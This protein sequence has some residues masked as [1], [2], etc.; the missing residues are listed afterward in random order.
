MEMSRRRWLFSIWFSLR[1]SL[2]E[3]GRLA[4]HLVLYGLCVA[5]TRSSCGKVCGSKWQYD[6]KS[7]PPFW[8]SALQHVCD[9]FLHSHGIRAVPD[10]QS[11]VSLINKTTFA[12]SGDC[13]Q[14]GRWG[15][16]LKSQASVSRTVCQESTRITCECPETRISTL[17]CKV[18][19][20]SRN[21]SSSR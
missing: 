2:L 7:R 3:D 13:W 10:N 15:F 16:S 4:N 6:E 1:L 21:L 20:R 11:N 18:S 8:I 9:R 5:F 14:L 17:R 19:V 12:T